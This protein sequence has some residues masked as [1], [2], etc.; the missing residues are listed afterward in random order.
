[1]SKVLPLVSRN[2]TLTFLL[3]GWNQSDFRGFQRSL[4]KGET[5]LTPTPTAS[6]LFIPKSAAKWGG[7]DL[8]QVSLNTPPAGV[9]V[10]EMGFCDPYL[11]RSST[12]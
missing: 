3:S 5:L 12:L 8:V 11:Q 4:S 1:M 9:P 6:F 7:F 2:K 10:W